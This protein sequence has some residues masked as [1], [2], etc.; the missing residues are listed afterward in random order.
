MQVPITAE[1]VTV[2]IALVTAGGSHYRLSRIPE[3]I[4]ADATVAAAKIL[5][6]A[7]VA[8]AKLKAEAE[9]AAK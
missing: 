2:V 4:R 5:A 8:A 9:Q 1:L 6:E 7:L 3:R